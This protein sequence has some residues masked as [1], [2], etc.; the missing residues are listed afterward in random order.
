[1]V[2]VTMGSSGTQGWQGAKSK[3]WS[4]NQSGLTQVRG[5]K[6][7]KKGESRTEGLGNRAVGTYACS[8]WKVHRQEAMEDRNSSPHD[9]EERNLLTLAQGSPDGCRG[10]VW[11]SSGQL[12]STALQ[13]Q[14][15]EDPKV[16]QTHSGFKGTQQLAVD[17]HE[18]G[19]LM[20]ENNWIK[21]SPEKSSLTF[22]GP[23]VLMGDFNHPYICWR[24]NTAE[25]EHSR[26]FP[27]CIKHK[28]LFQL[29]KE[30]TM[31]VAVLKLKLLN[32]EAHCG[33]EDQMQLGFSDHE[34]VEF[35]I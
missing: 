32:K 19:H 14:A 27:E 2:I 3:T 23:G 24:D 1:M 5:E 9:L 13:R 28:Y 34:I 26:R 29:A 21:L 7:R 10:N 20:R 30:P 18:G 35:R 11:E 4:P 8:G 12:I 25:H 15:R 17:L 6:G 22:T 16:Q 33:C 31:R